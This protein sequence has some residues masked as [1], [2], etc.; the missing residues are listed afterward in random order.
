MCASSTTSIT[1]P[2]R[3]SG[4]FGERACVFNNAGIAYA[5]SIECRPAHDDWRF[6][7]DVDL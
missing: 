1:S 7:I 3:R 5:G 4:V 6:V 2:M